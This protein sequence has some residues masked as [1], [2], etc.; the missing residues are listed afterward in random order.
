MESRL[1][2]RLWTVKS[3]AIMKLRSVFLPLDSARGEEY[4]FPRSQRPAGSVYLPATNDFKFES[5]QLA[6]TLALHGNPHDW[7]ISI[8]KDHRQVLVLPDC[9][10]YNQ[11]FV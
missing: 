9:N 8:A 3:R 11:V 5:S 4:M 7:S 6:T 10:V 2:K 1:N